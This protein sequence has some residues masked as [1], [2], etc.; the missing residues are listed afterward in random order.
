MKR[1]LFTAVALVAILAMAAPAAFAQAPQPKV[2]ISGFVDQI[3]SFSH[4]M[5]N[6]DTNITDDRDHEWYARTRMRPD[7]TAEVGTTKF[8][9]GLEIDM[10]YGQTGSADSTGNRFGTSGSYDLNTDVRSVI[11]VKWGYTEFELPFLP[12][13][14]RM[15]LGAQ[16]FATTYKT[17]VLATG[18]FA[19]INNRIALMPGLALNLT[20]AQIEE[21]G[22][23]VKY[24]FNGEDQAQVISLEWTPTKGIDLRPIYSYAFYDGGTSSSSRQGRGGV[25]TSTNFAN[26][27]HESRHTIGIDARMKFGGFYIDPTFFYQFGERQLTVGGSE[28]TQDRSAWLGDLRAGWQSG[29]L[30]LEGAFI[31]TSGNKASDDV[32]S[33]DEDLN[34]YEPIDTDTSFYAGWANIWALGIDYFNIVNARAS[35]LNPGNA[36]GYDKYGLM[37]AG[38][39]GSYALT[40]TFIPSAAVTASWTAKKVDTDGTITNTA[41]I[42]PSASASG[43][44]KYLGT[45]I[46]LGFTWRFAPN[47][48]LDVVGGYMFAGSAMESVSAPSSTTNPKP[49]NNDAENVYTGVARVRFSF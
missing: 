39:K 47:V 25:D 48:A 18:D 41:G 12:K 34:F 17:A 29:P 36:I 44:K 2:T 5:G 15:R 21:K 43:D 1:L 33:G 19:G 49:S 10:A 4:N 28:R 11:E 22:P 42:T 35:G 7:V 45:E 46:N 16:P 13:G 9:L 27:N 20:Y 23:G 6:Q 30:M 37:R 8:V 14:S 26:G 32:R 24:G 38:F 40:P 31:Y 3:M